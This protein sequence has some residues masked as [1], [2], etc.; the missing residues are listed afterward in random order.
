MGKWSLYTLH[1]FYIFFLSQLRDTSCA[2][3]NLWLME[4]AVG[5]KISLR[6]WLLVSCPSSQHCVYKHVNPCIFF[7][8]QHL[9]YS[10]FYY[11]SRSE[12]GNHSHWRGA[13]KI[14]LPV[15]EGGGW[16]GGREKRQAEKGGEWGWG[17]L[18]PCW[19]YAYEINKMYWT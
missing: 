7:H 13:S 15:F 17:V 18:S 8:T 1:G 3:L 10:L 9:T 16:Q 12:S 4:T 14:S 6:G 19:P 11:R 2:Q 5:Q